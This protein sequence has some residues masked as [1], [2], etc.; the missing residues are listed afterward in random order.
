M[1]EMIDISLTITPELPTWPGDPQVVLERINKIE[2]GANANVSRLDISVHTGTHVDAP[3]H[4]LQNGNTVENLDL[5]ILVGTAQVIFVDAAN[6]TIEINDL[7]VTGIKPG[8]TRLLLKTRNSEYWDRIGEGFQTN[9]AGLSP[10]ASQYL[11]ELGIKLVGIDYLSIAPFKRSRPTHE[12]LLQS[13]MIVIEGLDLRKVE[14]GFYT[15]VCLPIKLGKT[16]G[17]PARVILLNDQD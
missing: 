2:D 16:D 11:V 1:N 8:T 4:F 3:Y 14:P 6:D 7:K 9:F 5:N 17:A 13:E 12:V 10:E 15:L